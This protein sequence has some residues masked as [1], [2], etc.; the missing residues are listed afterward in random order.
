MPTK[1]EDLPKYNSQK[2]ETELKLHVD[3][4]E[5]KQIL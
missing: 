5:V 2:V 1:L 4:K 3:A